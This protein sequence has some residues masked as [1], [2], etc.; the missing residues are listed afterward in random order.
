MAR[1]NV[2]MTVEFEGEIEADSVEEAERLA[3]YDK[4]VQYSGLDSLDVEEIEEE[5]DEDEEED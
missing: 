2:R 3:I 4:T 1:Y 5:D